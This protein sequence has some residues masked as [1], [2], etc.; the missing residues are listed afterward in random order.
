MGAFA[1]P[2]A[3]LEQRVEHCADCFAGLT[4]SQ[5]FTCLAEDL[6][7]ADHHR[8]QSCDDLEQV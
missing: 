3:L 1:D 8:V 6:A 5:R 7:L 2:Q 4:P